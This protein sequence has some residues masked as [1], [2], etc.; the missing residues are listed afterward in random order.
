[1]TATL[2]VYLLGPMRA[3]AG[4]VAIRLPPRSKLLSLWGYLLVRRERAVPRTFLAYCFW[5][6]VP[7]AEARLNFRRHLHRLQQLLPPAPVERP[8]ILTEGNAVQW[9]PSADAWLDLAEFERLSRE[10]E[11]RELALEQYGGDLLEGIYDDWVFS[12]RERLR[13]LR[14]LDLHAIVERQ[15]ALGDLSQA[16][17]YAQRM[18]RHDPLREASYRA[19]MRLH[20]RSGD[21]AGV[22]RTFNACITVLERE[23]GVKPSGETV[24]AYHDHLSQGAPDEPGAA[25]PAQSG[26]AIHRGLPSQATSFVGRARD[27]EAVLAKLHDTRCLTLTGIGG[28]GKTRLAHA[29][30]EAILPRFADGACWVDL[31]T[32][33]DPSLLGETVASALGSREQSTR[34]V[35]QVLAEALRSKSML[36]ILDSC[37]HLIEACATL[38]RDLLRQGSDVKILATSTEPLGVPGESVWQVPPLDIPRSTSPGA[39]LDAASL[40]ASPSVDLFVE[41]ATAALPTFRLTSANQGAVIRLCQALDGLPLALELAAGRLKMLSVEQLVERLDDRFRLLAGGRRTSLPR[42]RTLAAVL[43]WSHA[44]LSEDERIL[45][46]RVSLFLGGFTLESAEAI[47]GSDPLA[48]TDV[49]PLLSELVDKSLVTVTRSDPATVRYSLLETVAHYARERLIESGE[50]DRVRQV[51]DAYFVGLVE[52]AGDRLLRGPDQEKWFWTIGQE[53]ANLRGVMSDAQAAGAQQVLASIA[54][55]LWPFWW[56]R[57]NVAEG[58]RWLASLLPLRMSLPDD[59]RARVLHAAGRLMALQGDAEGA[60][61]ALAE[62]L[63]VCRCLKDPPRIAEALTGL[64]VVASN[65]QDYAEAGRLWAEAL[66]VY[67][68]QDDPWGVARASNNLG[69]LLVY[70]G[71]Y[72]AA[73]GYLERSARLFRELRSTLG[74]SIAL[75]NLGRATLL[76]GET[77]R[78]EGFFGASLTIK[79]ALADKEG[80]AWNLEGLAGVAGGQGQM[81]RAARLFGAADCLRRE[82]SIPLAAPDAPLHQ[83]LLDQARSAGDAARWQACWDEGAAWTLEQAIAYAQDPTST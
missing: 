68:S 66:E 81:D 54:G 10:P 78:A 48:R 46:R 25:P 82:I 79:T 50:A 18:L 13:D 4:D 11:Q 62:N 16:I 27:L 34:P 83:R 9:N 1:M 69:D 15:E 47:A 22:V 73:T 20:A 36:L 65:L 28:V 76:Q 63:D 33:S 74:E 58:S 12:D 35:S 52:D 37:E 26:P 24:R 59:L 6:D 32:L 40:R 60:R 70:Q 23:L 8:W 41:R 7:E 53:Y 42:H 72:A 31:S 75:I 5:P 57:G 67:A 51:F 61:A 55:R 77:R 49:L 39:S 19:L 71:E 30:A 64:G 45:F 14:F 43:D 56:T 2:R 3:F 38:V 80:I 17:V 29:A 44:L 21:R